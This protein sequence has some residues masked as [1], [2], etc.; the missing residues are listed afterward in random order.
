MGKGAIIVALGIS[1]LISLVILNLN[2][3]AKRNT[4]TTVSFYQDTQARIIANSGIEIYLE[5]MRRNKA[6]KGTFLNNSLMS[7]KYDIYIYGPDT[8]LKLKCI[9][10]FNDVTHTSL[11]TARR[12]PV[13]IPSINSAIYIASQNGT[14]DLNGSMAIDGNDHLMNGTLGG[15]GASVPGMAVDDAADSV[16]IMN[17][18]RHHILSEIQG[19]GGAPSVRTVPDATDWL[20][21]TENYIFAAD[22]VLPTGTYP[23]GTTLGTTA[24]PKI[25]YVNGDVTFSGTSS[26]SGIMIINGNITFTGNFTFKGV[27]IA[28]GETSI[29]TKTVGNLAVI[30]AS[31]FV[32]KN[33]GIDVVGN[34]QF[35]YSSQAV[36]NAKS[37]L[38]SSR[39][40]IV[41]WWE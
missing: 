35:F 37:N 7:G 23:T 4:A 34:S 32:A 22:T 38:L 16:F 12:T 31:I 30:G 27:V 28:Y 24:S 33:I 39:F 2:A 3:N 25:S 29:Y 26:G 17:D 9:A 21:L 36:E 13:K 18:L 8:A 15:T 20:A 41:S 10:R 40:S 19:Q 14:A 5:K 6:F 1:I 11:V